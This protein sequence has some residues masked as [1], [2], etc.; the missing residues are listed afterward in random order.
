LAWWLFLIQE[1]SMSPRQIAF[2]CAPVLTALSALAGLPARA[3]DACALLSRTDA[4]ALLGEPVAGVTP[5][6]PE[7]DEESGGQ[8]TF[9]TWRAANGSL[10]VSVIEFASPADARR[11]LE[12]N[13]SQDRKDGQ[14]AKLVEERGVGERAFWGESPTSAVVTFLKSNKVAGIAIGGAGRQPATR[15]EALRKAAIAIAATL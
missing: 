4:A 15:K 7:R 5:A 10:V 13:L 1:Q 2:L 14:D 11:Q 3:A 12:A 9:C 6:G 8:L